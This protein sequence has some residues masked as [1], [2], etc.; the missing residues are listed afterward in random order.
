[1]CNTEKWEYINSWKI[2]TRK[3]PCNL[4][5]DLPSTTPFKRKII[6]TMAIASRWIYSIINI[7][8]K[9][10]RFAA[11]HNCDIAI[12]DKTVMNFSQLQLHATPACFK[13]FGWCCMLKFANELVYYNTDV[14]VHYIFIVDW[15]VSKKK[16]R[17]IDEVKIFCDS[18]IIRKFGNC[19]LY[20]HFGL[21]KHA[22]SVVKTFISS[23]VFNVNPLT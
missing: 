11:F 16:S 18:I 23:E 6:F 15:N 12:S 20:I 7:S 19:Y 5:N 9:S 21:T 4:E 2:K 8:R 10:S 3:K 17:M 13:H 22:R 1:M 14:T